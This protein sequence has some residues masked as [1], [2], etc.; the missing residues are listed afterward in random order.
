MKVT[1]LLITGASLLF[2]LSAS[3]HEVYGQEKLN[4]LQEH[5]LNNAPGKKVT[6]LTVDY[7]PGQATVPHRHDGAAVAYVLEGSV[8]SRVNDEAEHTFKA[9]ESWYEPAGS[10][11][12]VSRNASDNQ[13]AK[14]LVW[15]IGEE[16]DP[17]LVPLQH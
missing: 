2:S 16:K 17:I 6:V 4:V 13:P 7:A 15:V 14:L 9:G 10:R 11:H 12:P 3:A 5:V 1:T 8:V